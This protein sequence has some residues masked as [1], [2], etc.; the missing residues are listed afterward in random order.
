MSGTP[1]DPAAAAKGRRWFVILSI[2][3]LAGFALFVGAITVM[4]LRIPALKKAKY[5]VLESRVGDRPA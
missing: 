2:V 3:V 1:D 4:A 5:G